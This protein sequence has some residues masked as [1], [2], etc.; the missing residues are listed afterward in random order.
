MLDIRVCG[1]SELENLI[2]KWKPDYILSLVSPPNICG[3]NHKV[4][5]FSDYGEN[6]CTF[7]QIKEISEFG[8]T[9]SGRLLIHCEKGF[10]R[11]PAAAIIIL[12]SRGMSPRHALEE[13]MH[14]RPAMDP[15]EQMLELANEYLDA[16]LLELFEI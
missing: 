16:D 13:I 14:I 8:K 6:S 10:S 3:K 7:E 1:L 4:I 11:S 5:E 15:N 12:I 2:T 9:R